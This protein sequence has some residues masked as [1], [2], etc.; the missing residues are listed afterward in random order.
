MGK[1][2]PVNHLFQ[3]GKGLFCLPGITPGGCKLFLE[4][5]PIPE[6][7]FFKTINLFLNGLSNYCKWDRS[8]PI[9]N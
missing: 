6:E 1:N 2:H 4:E 7:F 9:A 8:F 3:G 5:N